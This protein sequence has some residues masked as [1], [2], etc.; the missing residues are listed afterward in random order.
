MSQLADAVMTFYELSWHYNAVKQ[1]GQS[2][3]A[4][5]YKTH[6]PLP[7]PDDLIMPRTIQSLALVHTFD[8]DREARR[9]FNF[10]I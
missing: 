7:S 3:G 10:F 9:R 2:A 6:P 4:C 1:P 5:L 8:I